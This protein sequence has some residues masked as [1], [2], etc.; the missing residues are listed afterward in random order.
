MRYAFR[1]FVFVLFSASIINAQD[2]S[3]E[4]KLQ[5]ILDLNNQIEPLEKEVLLPDAK[6]SEKARKE[7]LNVVRILPR[8]KYDRK[9]TIQGGGSY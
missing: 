6:D 8:E 2:L 4:Q 5:K 1:I 3:R 9:L 7:N